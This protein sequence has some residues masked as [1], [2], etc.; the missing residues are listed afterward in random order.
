MTINDVMKYIESE[1]LVI[2]DSHC[3]ICGGDYLTQEMEMEIID[4]I[5]YDICDCI[6][7]NCGHEKIFEFFA[8][9]VDNKDLK[10][11]KHILN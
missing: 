3:E 5:P 9:F 7:S 10:K 2:S 8:P 4:G 6:C 11:I 1:F